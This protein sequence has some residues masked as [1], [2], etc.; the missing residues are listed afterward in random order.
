MS[1]EFLYISDTSMGCLKIYTVWLYLENITWLI[2]PILRLG[3]K[4][5]L[6]ITVDSSDLKRTKSFPKSI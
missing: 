2:F 6:L 5:E 4:D 3:Y 1:E